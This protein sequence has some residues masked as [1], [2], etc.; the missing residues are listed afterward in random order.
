MNPETT[1]DAELDTF[2]R[3]LAYK[4]LRRALLDAVCHN[5]YTAAARWWLAFHP[6]AGELI[7]WIAPGLR[8]D[9]GKL[10]SNSSIDTNTPTMV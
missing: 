9:I 8:G 4:I 7:E 1:S 3:W 5:E 6:F 10:F 2:Y